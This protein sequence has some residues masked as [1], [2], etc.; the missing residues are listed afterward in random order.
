MKSRINII[1]FQNICVKNKR[2][3]KTMLKMSFYD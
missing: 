1:F 3:D 2:E